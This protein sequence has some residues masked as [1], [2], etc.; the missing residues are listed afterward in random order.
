MPLCGSD[1]GKPP[2]RFLDL[3][4]ELRNQVYKILVPNRIDIATTWGAP[5]LSLLRTSFRMNQEFSAVLYARSVFHIDLTISGHYTKFLEWIYGLSVE[6]VSK[7]VHFNVKSTIRAPRR[8]RYTCPN[9]HD[10]WFYICCKPYAS[11][12]TL[13]GGLSWICNKGWQCGNSHEE[14]NISQLA[15]DNLLLWVDTNRPGNLCAE[16]YVRWVR[17]ILD[18]ATI[19]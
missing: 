14:F 17:T 18:C 8:Y 15:A 10:A 7:I 13:H 5:D 16:D 19:E 1:L 4:A 6:D 2:F 3:P 11:V 12:C 9:D